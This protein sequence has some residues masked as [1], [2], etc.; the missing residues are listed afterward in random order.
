MS[1]AADR[2]ACAREVLL[3]AQQSVAHSLG[4]AMQNAVACQQAM[5]TLAM[6]IAGQL[7]GER[8][9]DQA[10]ALHAAL[11]VLKAHDPV[12]QMA[13]VSALLRQLQDMMA[14]NGGGVAAA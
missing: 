2:A 12:G 7:A 5:N 11:E 10:S 1:D 14:P 6:A 3:L 9:A 4:L 13:Q 8:S